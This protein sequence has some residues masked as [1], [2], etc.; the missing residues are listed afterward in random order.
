MRQRLLG[1]LVAALTLVL[2]SCGG[3]G[4]SGVAAGPPPLGTIDIGATPAQA[5]R[6]G[7]T[8]RWALD[9]LPVNFNYNQ[10]DGAEFNNSRVIAS[11][12]PKLWLAQPDGTVKMNENYLVSAALT[13]TNPEVVSYTLRDEATWSDGTPMTWL[14]FRAQWQALNGKN[15]AF[16]ISS[17]TGYQDIASVER[18]KSDK[19]AVVTF[20]TP[21][22]D[23]QTIFNPLYPAS[24]NTNPAVF[25]TGWIQGFPVT[26]G[27]FKVAQIDPVAKTITMVRDEKW[28]GHKPRVDRIIF[29][30]IQR[31]AQF[32]SLANNETDYAEVGVDVNAFTRAQSAP[33][34]TVRKALAPNFRH[35]TFNGHPGSIVADQQLRIAIQKGINRQAITR[36]LVGRIVPGATP[37]GNHIYVQGEDGYQDNS[38]IVT[39]DPAEASRML[40]TLGWIRQGQSTRAKNGQQLVLRDVIPTETP[41]AEQEARQV[42]QFLG[43]IGVKVDITPVPSNEFFNK[44]ITPGNFDIC[45]FAW[46]AVPFPVTNTSS[47]YGTRGEVQQNFGGI[48]NDTINKLFEQAG[49]EFDPARKIQLANQIDQEIWRTGHSLLLYQRPD[50]WGVRTGLANIGAF[51]ISDPIYTDIGFVQ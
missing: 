6:E 15:K 20:A 2:V 12:V 39:Y 13:S 48:G 47:I 34:V 46:I 26:A 37:L 40:D 36:A 8:F 23:W 44:H 10:V 4:G 19:Q 49:R 42:Q 7:G 33:G 14:D 27:P 1:V 16:L 51:G 3:N 43:A 41:Q 18:G 30:S 32:D 22:S 21:F 29:R 24:T 25:N 45:H 9:L 11:A 38:Q 35:I 5:L 17:S 31:V 50:V 28:W